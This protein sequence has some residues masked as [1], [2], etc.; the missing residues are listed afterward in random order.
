MQA[1]SDSL[2]HFTKSIE[3]LTGILRDGFKPK[4]SL[5]DTSMFGGSPYIAYPMV[6]FC[7]I[8]MS[9]ISD[10]SAFYGD[11]GIGMT[12][13]WGRRSQLQ[14]VLY[15]MPG[16]TLPVVA[17][18]LNKLAEDSPDESAAVKRIKGQLLVQYWNLLPMIKPVSGNMIIGG[19]VIEKDFTQENEWRYAPYHA[20][21]LHKSNFDELRDEFN[22]AMLDKTLKFTPNDVKYI[23]VKSDAE[24]P[25]IFDFIQNHLG[26]FSMNE[27]KVLISRIVSLETLARDL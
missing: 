15:A 17:L 22:A 10:H 27:L 20:K 3:Y 25:L 14:P 18:R 26:N 6:C 7:D 12:R 1:R 9:R 19:T 5:E 8:P 16:G 21:I 4:Y 13:E 11:Y 23:F 2:F 24:I